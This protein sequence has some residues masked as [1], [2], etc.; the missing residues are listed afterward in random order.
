[1]ERFLNLDSWP[2]REAFDYFRGFDKPYFNLCARVDAAPL[3]AAVQAL[4]G[5]SFALA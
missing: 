3:K 5:G 2:R 4:G 1:M